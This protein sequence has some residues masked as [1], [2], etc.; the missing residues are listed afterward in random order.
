MPTPFPLCGKLLDNIEPKIAPLVSA[1]HK[2]RYLTYS[3]CEGHDYT[4]RR[5][6]GL[7]LGRGEQGLCGGPGEGTQALGVE[8]RKFDRVANQ[9]I[10]TGRLK[11][12]QKAPKSASIDLVISSRTNGRRGR[13][14][15]PV[16]SIS[17]SIG[18]TTLT[19]S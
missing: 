17:S 8:L 2:K 16:R 12:H 9:D 7:V 10:D 15:K 18:A 6:V 14:L 19:F 3:S 11:P 5:Y 4:Y 13:T 1:L